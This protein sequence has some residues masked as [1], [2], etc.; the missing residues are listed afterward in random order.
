MGPNNY[1][2]EDFVTPAGLSTTMR[3]RLPAGRDGPKGAMGRR[4]RWPEG[5]ELEHRKV[6]KKRVSTISAGAGGVVGGVVAVMFA[7]D[8]RAGSRILLIDKSLKDR[9]SSRL[10]S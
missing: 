2:G 10:R 8:L 1:A 3:V 7:V 9:P 6:R 5:P 4:V